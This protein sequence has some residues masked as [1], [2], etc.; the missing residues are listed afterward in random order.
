[1]AEPILYISPSDGGKGIYMTSGTRLLKFLGNYD[2]LGTGNPPSIILNGYTG[3]QL[4]LVPTS[5]GGVSTPVGSASAYA[6]YVTG[7]SMNG[8]RITF[9]TS[10]NNMGW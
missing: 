8:N 7:Y 10:N 4:Y 9:T 6:W 3:G 1:M 5:F 2:T